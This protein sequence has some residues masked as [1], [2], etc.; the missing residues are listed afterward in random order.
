MPPFYPINIS[1]SENPKEILKWLKSKPVDFQKKTKYTKAKT[2][3]VTKTL[4]YDL[5]MTGCAA[6]ADI[7][8]VSITTEAD[9]DG[10]DSYISLHVMPK[11]KIDAGSAKI[12]GFS[13]NYSNGKKEMVDKD[14]IVLDTVTSEEAAEKVTR[15]LKAR[16]DTNVEQILLVAHNGHSFDQNRFVTLIDNLVA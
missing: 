9:S 3:K 1:F 5:E 13:I 14:G 12:H 4:F 16:I 8:Q 15:Y 6:N 2:N 10:P 11:K 7:L